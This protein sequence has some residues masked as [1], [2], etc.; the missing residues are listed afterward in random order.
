MP[1]VMPGLCIDLHSVKA[2]VTGCNALHVELVQGWPYQCGR[3]PGSVDVPKEGC[4][5]VL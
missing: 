3:V 1:S 5:A 4:D 2:S